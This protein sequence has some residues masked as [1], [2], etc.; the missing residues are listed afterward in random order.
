MVILGFDPGGKNQ[1]GWCV[2]QGTTSGHLQLRASNI[3]SHAHE[4]VTCALKKAA[5]FGR[6]EAAGIDSPLFWV[7]D[8]DRKADKSI[9]NAMKGLGAINVGG[10]VQQVNSLRGACLSQGMMAAHLLRRELP[11]I[12][13]TESHPK[14]LLWLLRVAGIKLP[15]IEIGINQL[16]DFME[17]ELPP[18]VRS[19][20][21]RGFGCG[22]GLGDD[23]Q[24]ERLARPVSG[25]EKCVYSHIARGILDA[26]RNASLIPTRH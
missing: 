2:A 13:I 26:S 20:K 17:S 8:G 6:V 19:R 23:Q 4:A 9:R 7:A 14:A 16:G 22:G 21:R 18:P 10:T 25:R 1:F 15:V 12:R 11:E 3:A 5:E 24:A